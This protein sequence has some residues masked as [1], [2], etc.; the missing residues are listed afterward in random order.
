MLPTLYIKKKIENINKWKEITIW[1][2]KEEGTHY[3]IYKQM[4]MLAGW[5]GLK[6]V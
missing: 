6:N 5:A 1:K 3:G 2:N 4:G